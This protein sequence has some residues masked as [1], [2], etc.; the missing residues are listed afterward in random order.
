MSHRQD[1]LFTYM[2]GDPAAHGYT[3]TKDVHH[4]S[5]G[6]LVNVTRPSFIC[7]TSS[8]EL[9]AS[10]WLSGENGSSKAVPIIY[11]AALCIHLRF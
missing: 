11:K 1:F 3:S 4:Q 6:L 2:G 9:E 5:Q 7:S 8:K 10:N